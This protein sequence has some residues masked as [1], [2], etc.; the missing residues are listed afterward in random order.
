MKIV[1]NVFLCSVLASM[2]GGCV[3][4]HSVSTTSVPADRS[5]PVEVETSRFIFLLLNFDNDYVNDLTR[6]LAKKCPGGKV[7]GVLTKL[8]GVTYFPVFAHGVR[9]TVRGYCVE[10]AGSS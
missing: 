3:H 1:R 9:V 8:E 10:Q 4:L 6:D 2:L 7:Q 5:K